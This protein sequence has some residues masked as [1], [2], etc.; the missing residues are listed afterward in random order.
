MS[1]L[2][3]NLSAL[4]LKATVILVAVVA[5]H[6]ALRRASAATRHLC[7]AMAMLGV[8]LLPLLSLSLPVWQLEVLPHDSA[9]LPG[10]ASPSPV[11]FEEELE[12]SGL[13]TPP[14]LSSFPTA[15][16]EGPATGAGL[17][18]SLTEWLIVTWALGAALVLTKLVAGLLR[19][20]WIARNGVRVTDPDT[21][22]QLDE[23]VNTL[24]L[25][26][27]PLLF[28]SEHAGVP[29]VWGWLRP[30]LIIPLRFDRW[31]PD[32]MRAVLLHELGHLKRNDW[33]VLL[34]GRIVA[35]IYWF[36]PLAW[37]VERCAKHECER[38]CDDIVVTCGTKPSDYASHL[39]S[40]ARGISETPA[41]VR[42]ALA[43]VR[44]SQLNSRLRSILD[45]FLR[46]NYP[47]RSVITGLGAV[48]LLV[49]VPLASLQLT[50]QALAN[51]PE[52]DADV[53]L[54]QHKHE[55]QK[56]HDDLDSE[57]SEGEQAYKQG[58]QLHSKGRYEAAIEA[59]EA[60]RDLGYKHAASTYNIACG[61]ALMG[62][63]GEAMS[64]LDR[65]FDAGFG[66][67]E[68]LVEDSDFNPIRRDSAFQD[69]IDRA[70][71]AAGMERR[72]PEHY[73]YR[74]TLELF[75]KLEAGGS[76]NGKKWHYVG[77]KLLGMREY[78]LAIEALT[79]AAQNSGDAGDTSMYNLA[80]AYSLVGRERQ[81]LSWLEQSVDAGFG[82][83]ELLLNDT[84]LDNLRDTADFRRIMDKSEFL[85]LERFMKKG[86]HESDQSAE[87]WEQVIQEY[88]GYVE[89]NP[90]SGRA[91]FNLSYA[92]HLSGRYDDAVG[93]FE[94][95][96]SQHGC[97]AG[98]ARDRGGI[99]H[100]PLRGARGRR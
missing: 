41:S 83:H 37:F 24:Q 43:V 62:D 96:A 23:C 94:K 39:L 65:A 18:P 9:A 10:D 5:A 26:V 47:S 46:R 12:T 75:E 59:F 91:W 4:L 86:S 1:V 31:T 36:H 51:E 56:M 57:A 67:P 42:A 44:R 14:A 29:L 11:P 66:G 100:V 95:A 19:M 2:K 50:E 58:Y 28:A 69:Y 34:L 61:H 54:A 35:A 81:A 32:R 40:I 98:C 72:S 8:A 27:H 52:T 38:A 85:S 70:F 53:M 89:K 55:Q 80:C 74:S 90:S 78:D 30:A 84:D 71:E 60:A 21:L 48:L 92:L 17:K 77:T 7:L 25:Q 68:T 63:S 6:F 22:R 45:P 73:P 15:R 20:R 93:G 49:L 88:T 87:P 33:P 76:T 64:W 99:G 13:S 79:V 97:R 3:A 16:A 82:Q